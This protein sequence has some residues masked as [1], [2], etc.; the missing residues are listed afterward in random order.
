MK[1]TQSKK[2][3]CC[4]HFKAFSNYR[5][6]TR[7]LFG[8]NSECKECEIIKNALYKRTKNGVV[9]K[10]YSHQKGSSKS[11]CLPLPSY[12]KEEFKDWIFSQPLFHI[13]Y[14]SWSSSGYLKNLKPSIDRKDDSL[15]Y[16][17][18]NIQLM[19]WE[20]NNNKN[21]IARKQG[22]PNHGG[23]KHT[24]VSQ[25]TK[26]GVFIAD[27]ISIHEAGRKLSISHT[28]ILG[29]C[30]HKYGYKTSGGFCWEYKSR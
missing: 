30:Q 13:L 2:C 20:D 1:N 10:L 6:R 12:S 3:T 11:R 9:T 17:F 19:S 15:T 28:G 16:S 14:D 22:F 5:K 25:F 24:P 4:R 27:F 21:H 23:S 8:L 29:C 7:G 26:Y 18:S